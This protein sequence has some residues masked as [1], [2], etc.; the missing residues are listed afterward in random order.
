VKVCKGMRGGAKVCEGVRGFARASGGV[1][2]PDPKFFEK[3][4]HF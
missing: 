4:T 3:K 1:F 2:Y